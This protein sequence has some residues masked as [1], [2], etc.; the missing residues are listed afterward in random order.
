MRLSSSDIASLNVFRVVAEHGSFVSA[1]Y[2]LNISQ[3]SVS[4]HIVK[5]EEKFG[6]RLCHRG[7]GGFSLTEKGQQ[8]YEHACTLFQH[9]D[10]FSHTLGELRGELSGHLRIGIPDNAVHDP[11]LPL[12][13]ALRNFLSKTK[14]IDVS[15]EVSTP[16]DLEVKL[17]SGSLNLAITPAYDADADLVR[18]KLYEEEQILCCGKAHPLFTEQHLTFGKIE[19]HNFVVRRYR[20]PQELKIFKKAKAAATAPNMEALA[21]FVLSGAF[22]SYLPKSYAMLW[23]KTGDMRA[24]QPSETSF[25]VNFYL[26]RRRDAQESLTLRTFMDEIRASLAGCDDASAAPLQDRTPR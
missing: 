11:N 16:A 9:V 5:L 23:I 2:S 20:D 15:L 4:Q 14:T 22:L 1:Q 26:M 24:L 18:E 19:A 13:N 7:R 25:N 10:E 8:I 21:I 6:F 17:L 12:A 3:S